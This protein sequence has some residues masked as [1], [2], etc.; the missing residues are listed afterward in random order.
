MRRA[1]FLPILVALIGTIVFMAPRLAKS[2]LAQYSAAGGSVAPAHWDFS[3]FPVQWSLNPTI[4]S[5]VSGAATPDSVVAA[6][7][8]TWVAAPNTAISLSRGADN[9]L[10]SP[11]FDGVN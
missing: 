5:N 6:S 3:Q 8:S 4:G 10:S 7:F 11:A 1:R 9:Q 2:Y